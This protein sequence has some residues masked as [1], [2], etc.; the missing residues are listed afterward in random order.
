VYLQ[1]SSLQEV[2]FPYK[3]SEGGNYQPYL[4]IVLSNGKKTFSVYA[5][6]DTG[7]DMTILP[8]EIASLLEVQLD[9]L[10]TIRISC[11]GG[12]QFSAMPSIKPITYTIP[13]I[14]GHRRIQWKGTAYFADGEEAVLL[15]HK[16]CLERFDVTFYGKAQR[17]SMLPLF[18]I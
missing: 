13:G 3:K 5:L 6:V 12:G 14:K 17:F 4:P 16:D 2:E 8:R 11:A 18:K 7:A 9:D 15:G 1:I 10:Q